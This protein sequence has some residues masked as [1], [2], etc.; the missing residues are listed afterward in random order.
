M[1]LLYRNLTHKPNIDWIYKSGKRN[2]PNDSNVPTGANSKLWLNIENIEHIDNE[3]NDN[4]RSIIRSLSKNHAK[5]IF[6]SYWVGSG[7]LCVWVIITSFR[8]S[9]LHIHCINS[10]VFVTNSTYSEHFG[11]KQWNVN[12]CIFY[13]MWNENES[14]W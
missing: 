4:S 3:M 6:K 1:L 12:K 13:P 14:N 9:A 11:F 8:F 5:S 2:A 10:T 7:S